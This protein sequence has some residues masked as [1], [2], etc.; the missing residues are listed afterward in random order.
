MR[1]NNRDDLSQIGRCEGSP[2]PQGSQQPR[3]FWCQVALVILE[4]KTFDGMSGSRYKFNSLAI[5]WG[6]PIPIVRRHQSRACLASN[7]PLVELCLQSRYW[8]SIFRECHAVVG[9]EWWD[10]RQGGCP[11]FCVERDNISDCWQGRY[12]TMGIHHWYSRLTPK[13]MIW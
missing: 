6:C 2:Q 3:N 11:R 5:G 1:R 10:G 7:P 4:S 8:W 12:E 9:V 13:E